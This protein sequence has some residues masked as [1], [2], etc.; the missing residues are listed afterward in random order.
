MGLEMESFS[1]G[2]L[3]A[4]SFMLAACISMISVP[5]VSKFAAANGL[6]DGR[7][8]NRQFEASRKIHSGS[9]PRFGGVAMVLAFLGAISILPAGIPYQGV[10]LGSLAV[11][12]CGV[13]DDFTPLPA[14][15]R[16]AVQIIAA[17][18]AI[19][20][21]Q[22]ALDHITLT[23]SLTI[24]L[25]A[26]VS[27]IFSTFLIVGAIN[28]INLIDGLD[29]LAAGIVLIGV[30]LLS[31]ADFVTTQSATVLLTFAL[32]MIG[33][34]FGF[35][36]Y[37][38]HPASIFMGDGGSNWLGFM[39][40]ALLLIALRVSP[41]T[42][43]SPP[44]ISVLLTFSIPII[45][46]AV[47]MIRRI[48]EKRSPFSADKNHFHHT[49]LRIGLTHSQSVMTIYFLAFA[50]GVLGIFPA[51]FPK[52]DFPWVPYAAS[53]VLLLAVPACAKLDDDAVAAAVNAHKDFSHKPMSLKFSS[54]IRHWENLNRYLL[55]AILI[56]GPALSGQ[57][58]AQFANWSM[59]VGTIIVLST[60]IPHTVRGAVFFDSFAIC[61]AAV[62]ILVVNNLNPMAIAWEGQPLSIHGIYNALFMV[63]FISSF[64]LFL[65]TARRRSLIFTPSDFLLLTIPL[66]IL[67]LPKS[68]QAQ[69]KLDLISLRSLVIFMALRVLYR[70]R[71]KH[72]GNLKLACL[73]ALIWVYLVAAHGVRVLY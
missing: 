50:F 7:N 31:F 51:I 1:P 33:A 29:G 25:P 68:L 46:T 71:P 22:L 10:L 30:S 67:L 64:L 18:L 52:Y 34:I 72:I 62:V 65:A 20:H 15:A 32:P 47:V 19:H 13:I 73:A 60:F 56:L 8:A 6:F 36:R 24:M 4:I 48:R 14:K 11:F 57:V 3:L 17:V 2:I 39:S 54:A 66:V 38:T 49:L 40:G 45:D 53:V 63:L 44:L 16:L 21:D 43:Q 61:A 12:A 69:Y 59:I 27:M 41:I 28:A 55:F 37:N 35:L 5:V 70:R 9:I 26:P 58:P 42:G 23:K